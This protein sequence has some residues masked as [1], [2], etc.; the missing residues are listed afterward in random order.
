[1]AF[2]L[3]RA[4]KLIV[5]QVL[6]FVGSTGSTIISFILPGFFYFKLFRKEAGPLKWFALALA[7]YGL[8]VMGFWWVEVIFCSK[9]QVWAG[10]DDDSLTFNII[11]LVSR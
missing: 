3:G 4:I 2:I 10:A 1:M 9:L 11:R 8:C 7:I 6:G 5:V